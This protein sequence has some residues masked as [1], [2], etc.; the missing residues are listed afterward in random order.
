MVIASALSLVNGNQRA[1]FADFRA[2]AR[3]FPFIFP[4]TSYFLLQQHSILPFARV[5]PKQSFGSLTPTAP[6]LPPRPA[7]NRFRSRNFLLFLLFRSSDSRVFIGGYG[8][9]WPL[10]S[11]APPRSFCL[12]DVLRRALTRESMSPTTLRARSPNAVAFKSSP[13]YIQRVN[14]SV[15]NAPLITGVGR[16]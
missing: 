15:P 14:Y 11:R 7:A 13:G 3:A 12:D 8:P 1:S 2:R 5:D 4:F 16:S 9:K 10:L 6:L